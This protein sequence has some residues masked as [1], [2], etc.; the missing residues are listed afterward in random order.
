MLAVSENKMIHE[1]LAAWLWVRHK[2]TRVI[3]VSILGAQLMLL[4]N[5]D[6]K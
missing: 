6:A 3:W 4:S 2:Q 5:Q 1:Q